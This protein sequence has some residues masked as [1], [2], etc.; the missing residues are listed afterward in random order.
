MSDVL[1]QVTTMVCRGCGYTA[2]PEDPRPFR[3]PNAGS[4]DTDHVLQRKIDIDAPGLREA[5]SDH[6][7]DPFIR[8]RKL[9]R[10]WHTAMAKGMRDEELIGIVRDLEERIG[11]AFR[12]TPLYEQHGLAHTMDLHADLWVKN[13]TG[14]VAHSHKARHLMGIAIWL[15]VVDR[16]NRQRL[17]IAS[18]GN[19]AIAAAAVA[20][21][22]GRELDVFIP[23]DAGEAIVAKLSSLG[24]TIVR[25]E[26]R[27]G[28]RGDPAYLRFR[29]AVARGALPFTVQGNENALAIEGGATLGWEMVSQ[30]TSNRATLDRLFI[31]VGGGALASSVIS[32]FEDAGMPLPRIHAVQTSVSPLKRAF[33]RIADLDY[34]IHHRSEFM[35]PWERPGRSVATGI[36]DD[37]T[38]DWANVVHGMLATGG[39]PIVVS[40]ELL[41]EA[42]RIA[43]ASTGIR[44]SHTGTAGLAGLMDLQR[45][46]EIARN[47]AVGVI[48]TG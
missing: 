32:A 1:V 30:L 48:F 18:C 23:A 16:G 45:R 12:V 42:N 19:A 37:E 27:A 22:M 29:E 17:A 4:D 15:S 43:A 44:A 34:A 21:G 6:E 33:D 13:E 10:A 38:Y 35:W 3:C 26:R 31:Q 28:E 9:T 5:F 36:L 2:P 46:G 47:E 14:N 40:E 24:A 41:V 20:R 39:F 25:C 11:E 8:Y 7:P